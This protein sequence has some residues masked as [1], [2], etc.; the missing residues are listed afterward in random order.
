MGNNKM[1][2][3]WMDGGCNPGRRSRRREKKILGEPYWVRGQ[4][5][6]KNFGLM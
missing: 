3:I 2:R 5:V 6:E 4:K 1:C